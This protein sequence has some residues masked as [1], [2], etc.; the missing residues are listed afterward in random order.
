MALTI[1][2][3][4]IRCQYDLETVGPPSQAKQFPSNS[5]VLILGNVSAQEQNTFKR[6]NFLEMNTPLLPI[7]VGG[8]RLH[9]AS[10]LRRICSPDSGRT[11]NCLISRTPASRAQSFP[12]A[13][14][15][16]SGPPAQHRRIL[17]TT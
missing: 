7:L 15:R 2:P 3:S 17:P 5:S 6:K 12:G 14:T 10:G 9:I 1:T 11:A 8:Q 13:T 16:P 4:F